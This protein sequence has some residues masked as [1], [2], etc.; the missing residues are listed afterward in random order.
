MRGKAELEATLGAVR[1]AAQESRGAA[2][3]LSALRSPTVG[4]LVRSLRNELLRRTTFDRDRAESMVLD[5]SATLAFELALAGVL[6]EELRLT[7]LPAR[8]LSLGARAGVAVSP[9]ATAMIFAAGCA[10]IVGDGE[11]IELDLPAI[12]R[13]AEHAAVTRPYHPIAGDI[14]LATAD[15]NP[16]ASFG[17]EPGEPGNPVDLGGH[18]PSAW[19]AAL[20]DALGI[21]AA[22]LPDLAREIELYVRMIVPTGHHAETH[23][24]ASYRESIGAIYLTLHP[25]VMTLAEA[26]IHEFSHNKL[27]ALFE[28]DPVIENDS[29]ARFASPVRPD[30]RP[31]RGVLLAVHAFL[32]VARLYEKM[33]EARH[34]LARGHYFPSA[35]RRSA[36]STARG[37]APSSSTRSPRRWGAPCSTRSAA[38]TTTSP[39]SHAM[40]SRPDVDIKVPKSVLPGE[41]LHVHLRVTGLSVTPIDFIAVHFHVNEGTRSNLEEGAFDQRAIVRETVKVAE[42]GELGAE[43]YRYHA[44]FEVPSDLPPSYLGTLFEHRASVEIHVSIPWWPDVR[45][46]YDVAILAAPIERPTLTPFTGSSE[47]D[48]GAFVEVSLRTLHFAPGDTIEGALAF[49]N[50]GGADVQD[51]ELSLLSTELLAVGQLSTSIRVHSAFLAASSE[52]EG[53]QIPSASPS[54]PRSRPRS[55]SRQGR[56]PGSSRCASTSA[57]RPTW[58]IA[59]P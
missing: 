30:P 25:G 47:R 13:G 50:L 24:S 39:S 12:A 29:A 49:G 54:P 4:A 45:E 46:T 37:R 11:R 44:A 6:A 38:G 28:L 53:R 5:L 43:V 59:S 19:A 41:T 21:I 18:A 2:A 17:A 23:R 48:A 56:C 55:R 34:P 3:I 58:S 10:T 22:H 16:R 31:L 9:T 26:L 36:P 33:T 52:S 7:R 20:R 15:N 35:S 1:R 27:H 42:E 8:I 57:A 32:P 14:A 51:I 40:R